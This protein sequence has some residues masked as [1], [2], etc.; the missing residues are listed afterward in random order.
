MITP[1]TLSHDKNKYANRSNQTSFKGAGDIITTVLQACEKYPMV[2]VSVVDIASTTAPRTGVDLVTA[3][4]A[5]GAETFRR[6]VS[7]LVVN[8]LIPSFFVLGS[9]S[10]LNNVFMKE[11]PGINMAG[12]WADQETIETFAKIY[13]GASPENKTGSFVRKIIEG[14]EG[15]N[16]D[17][18]VKYIDV[19]QEHGGFEGV[20][21]T[22]TDLIDNTPNGKEE[23]KA[24]NKA[25]GGVFTTLA[26]ATKATETIKL[27]G[28][29]FPSNLSDLLRDM[30]DLGRKFKKIEQ[31]EVARLTDRLPDEVATAVG[32]RLKAFT[33]MSTKMV[34]TK[35]II[36]LA[37]VL[38]LAM[39]MQYINRAIT[40]ATYHQKGAPI[41]KDFGKA[42]TNRELTPEEKRKFFTNKVLAGTAMV[43]LAVLSMVAEKPL[44]KFKGM[45]QFKGMFPTMDQARWVSTAT[46]VS[47]LFA[48]E[49]PNELRESLVRDL[50]T[51]SGLYFLG[52]YL[53]KGTATIMEAATKGSEKPVELL[54][55]FYDPAENTG[56]IKKFVNWV[57]NTKL[58][59]YAEVSGRNVN[60]RS[61]C[62]V[63]NIGLSVLLLGVIVPLWNRKVTEKK[64]AKRKELEA[65]VAKQNI[66]IDSKKP[67]IFGKFLT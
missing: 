13:Q 56:I 21:R 19:A 35:S 7:G 57:K 30:V 39:S 34:N 11:F 24:A 63:A 59:S 55:K 36:G 61:Y 54:N 25:L 43:G 46:F 62:Q 17:K 26:E 41:Y 5:A 18:P 60:M 4:P 66:Q 40:R 10:V 47:R 12:S 37:V 6:E 52:D 67:E 15:K 23:T 28:D 2:N 50:I 48:S 31:D 33:E 8:C 32:N 65:L 9:A 22:L 3:G 64:E 20:I 16:I 45:L 38:P 51:F 44:S 1:V 58:K 27:N 53:A 29:S 42:D 49:D 14:L